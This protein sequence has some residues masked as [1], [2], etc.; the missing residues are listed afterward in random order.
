MHPFS[1]FIMKEVM[2]MTSRHVRWY[3]HLTGGRDQLQCGCTLGTRGRDSS[4]LMT[5]DILFNHMESQKIAN[6]LLMLLI[7][8][9]WIPS[10]PDFR[11]FSTRKLIVQTSLV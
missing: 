1:M 3:F 4:I 2:W 10:T 7:L 5:K 9:M 8:S 11:A 6:R